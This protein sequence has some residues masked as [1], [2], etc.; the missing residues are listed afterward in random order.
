M[1]EIQ[2][3][4]QRCASPAYPPPPEEHRYLIYNIGKK[5][6]WTKDSW[7]K[8]ANFLPLVRAPIVSLSNFL[9]TDVSNATCRH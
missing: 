7:F 2:K 4:I 8:R 5:D 3:L 6:S 9:M 1:K